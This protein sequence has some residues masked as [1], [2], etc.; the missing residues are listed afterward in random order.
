MPLVFVYG[1]LLSGEG[2]NRRFLT[3]SKKL[4]DDKIVG[5]SMYDLGAFPAISPCDDVKKEIVGE[6]WEISDQILKELDYLEGYPRFYDRIEVGTSM[7]EAWVYYHREAPG[8]DPQI[9]SGNWKAHLQEKYRKYREH[10]E[11][12]K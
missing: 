3:T 2:N 5:F 6:V 4:S 8:L 10:I 1:T 12:E 11:G 9:L 7:G